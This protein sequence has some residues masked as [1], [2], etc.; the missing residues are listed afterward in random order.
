MSIKLVCSIKAYLFNE[1]GFNGNYA[2]LDQINLLPKEDL[3]CTI[4]QEDL[5]VPIMLFCN[6]IFCEQ[7]IIKWFNTQKVSIFLILT[8]FRI[9]QFAELIY[10]ILL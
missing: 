1:L 2:T 9:V 7:C 6:H 3:T 5:K 4:C 8:N 10:H